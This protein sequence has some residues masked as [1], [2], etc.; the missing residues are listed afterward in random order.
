MDDTS[1][2][3]RLKSIENVRYDLRNTKYIANREDEKGLNIKLL[4]SK[5]DMHV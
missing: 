5:T 4:Q 1:N 3:T 2:N